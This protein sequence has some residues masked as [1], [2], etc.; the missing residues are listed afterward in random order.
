M[1]GPEELRSFLDQLSESEYATLLELM[2]DDGDAGEFDPSRYSVGAQGP[3]NPA[4]G[5]RPTGG[6]GL[7]AQN[8]ALRRVLRKSGPQGAVAGRGASA[9]DYDQSHENW[10]ETGGI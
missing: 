3:G 4:Q 9:S 5:L 1:M 7:P 8:D 6:P 10:T 2:T